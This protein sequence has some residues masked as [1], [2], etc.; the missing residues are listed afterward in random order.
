MLS[1][2]SENSIFGV[3]KI[4]IVLSAGCINEGLKLCSSGAGMQLLRK[5]SAGVYASGAISENICEQSAHGL[6]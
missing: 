2:L 3:F 1:T 6:V 5:R 4:I